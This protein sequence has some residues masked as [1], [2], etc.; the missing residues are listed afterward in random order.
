MTVQALD[1]DEENSRSRETEYTDS[2]S[3][4]DESTLVSS[5]PRNNAQ[6]SKVDWK[7]KDAI[8]T[9]ENVNTTGE[10]NMEASITPDDVIQAGEFGARDDISSFLPVA[11]NSTDFESSILDAKDYEEPHEEPSRPGL[12]WREA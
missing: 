10:V 1:K 9:S 3:H 7:D 12:G 2:N 6:V 4:V 5:S 8:E 11:S